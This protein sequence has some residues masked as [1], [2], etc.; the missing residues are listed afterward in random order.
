MR[1]QPTERPSGAEF[2]AVITALDIDID[3]I[4]CRQFATN[5][6]LPT[7]VDG[8]P[9][10]RF[11]ANHHDLLVSDSERLSVTRALLGA[12]ARVGWKDAIRC[13][14]RLTVCVVPWLLFRVSS[15]AAGRC[16]SGGA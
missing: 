14:E 6:G 12:F 9:V 11:L 8:P 4:E 1:L 3:S 2:A 13:V 15:A 7:A 5:A 16:C 10:D